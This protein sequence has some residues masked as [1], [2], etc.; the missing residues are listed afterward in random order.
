MCDYTFFS[1]HPNWWD[2]SYQLFW[3]CHNICPLLEQFQVTLVTQPELSSLSC[4]GAWGDAKKFHSNLAFLLISPKKLSRER[5]HLGLLWYGY[6]PT[7]PKSPLWMRQWRN[8]PYSPLP[9]KIGPTPLC[10]SMIDAQ[11]VPFPKE[12]HLSTMIEGVPS[13]NMCRHLHQLEVHQLLQLEGQVVYPEG[14]IGAWS[15]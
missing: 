4:S 7:K 6:T 14:L 1:K 13:R 8:S 10:S 2:E 5:W 9:V 12:G 15:W 11:Y 3:G